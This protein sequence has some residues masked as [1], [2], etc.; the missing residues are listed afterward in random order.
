MHR[1]IKNE[2]IFHER[3][4]FKLS[5]SHGNGSY[6][7]LRVQQ[8]VYCLFGAWHSYGHKPAKSIDNRNP[9]N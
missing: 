9:W 4:D 3:F 1:L 8:F 2:K 6:R 5:A 7:H